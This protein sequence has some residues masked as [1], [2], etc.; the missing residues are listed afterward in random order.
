MS[1]QAKKLSVLINDELKWLFLTVLGHVPWTKNNGFSEGVLKR[2][3]KQILLGLEYL[4]ER[5]VI[6]RDIK[7]ANILLDASCQSVKLADFGCS[8]QLTRL[9]ALATARAFAPSSLTP[10]IPSHPIQFAASARTTWKNR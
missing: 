6:H 4:H 1:D 10:C 5:N 9:V 2:Y 3:S 7:G 8:K